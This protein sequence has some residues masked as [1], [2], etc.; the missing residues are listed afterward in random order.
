[1]G[2]PFI[3]RFNIRGRE[4]VS[5]KVVFHIFFSHFFFRM[6]LIRIYANDSRKYLKVSVEDLHP[7]SRI[8]Q[9][10]LKDYTK[11]KR[12]HLNVDRDMIRSI[13]A[14]YRHNVVI[15]KGKTTPEEL[16]LELSRDCVHLEPSNPTICAPE[17]Q[18]LCARIAVDVT[19]WPRLI[20]GM[21]LLHEGYAPE[22]ATTTS[23][24]L[25]QFVDKPSPRKTVSGFRS[26]VSNSFQNCILGVT[27][28]LLNTYDDVNESMPVLLSRC[29]ASVHELQK[30]PMYTFLLNELDDIKKSATW[31][32]EEKLTN[33]ITD[34]FSE[35]KHLNCYLDFCCKQYK[36]F[37]NLKKMF[38]SISDARTAEQ[39][40]LAY[41]FHKQ[42]YQILEWHRFSPHH[43]LPLIYPTGWVTEDLQCHRVQDAPTVL[44]EK[45]IP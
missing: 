4:F 42:G 25:I 14:S 36:T 34:N 15:L 8:K 21:N 33:Y 10:I 18:A 28:Y 38:S 6:S 12:I 26:T 24:V 1:M 13:V 5:E 16:Y 20:A 30:L 41:H 11:G 9:T 2:E 23:Q 37:P 40:L 7:S 44:I 17:V 43:M 39:Q 35:L 45:T 32:T 31:P 3:L 27:S 19:T 29:N 22:W